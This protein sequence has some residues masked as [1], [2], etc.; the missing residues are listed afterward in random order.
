[1][2]ESSAIISHLP[3]RLLYELVGR[4]FPEDPR[5]AWRLYEYFPRY[6][7]AW[8]ELRNQ[9]NRMVGTTAVHKVQGLIIEP[10]NIC[11]LRCSHCTPQNNDSMARGMMS[12][13]LYK[14]ILNG[15]P[16]LSAIVLTWNGEPMAH[17]GIFDMIR[18]ARSR[19]IHVC[20]YT[21]ATLLDAR[22]RMALI[23]ADLS[24]LIVS[25]EGV[26][27]D[28]EKIRG[29]SYEAVASNLNSLLKL[30]RNSKSNMRI[31]LNVTKVDGYE[32]KN[33]A[34]K[35]EWADRV[36]FINFEPH[37]AVTQQVRTSACRTMFRSATIAWDGTVSP[38]CVDMG[39]TMTYGKLEVGDNPLD[40][41]NGDAAHQIREEHLAGAYSKICLNCPGFYG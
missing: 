25:M 1:M 41:I 14:S 11:N 28:F 37:M 35:K 32:T 16:D 19:G 2:S 5:L 30:R 26:G 36:D 27:A 31:R 20:M 9:W 21:N 17:T 13:E 33:E 34:V 7:N 3:L 10:T 24:E 18:V 8:G 6:R 15:L 38:C 39:Q 23:E 22:R 12:L 40:I 4:V 29:T